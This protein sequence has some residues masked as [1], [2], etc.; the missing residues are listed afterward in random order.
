MSKQMT[1]RDEFD[2]PV[3]PPP[4]PGEP[5]AKVDPRLVDKLLEQ[6]GEGAELL[7]RDGLLSEL[8]KSVL[9]RAL[10]AEVTDHLGYDRGDPAGR[11]SGNS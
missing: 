11:G 5:L 1:D 4:D 7:G 9:E 2:A 3:V 8:T 10:D 6:A